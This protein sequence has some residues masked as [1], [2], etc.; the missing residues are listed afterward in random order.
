MEEL[1]EPIR[2]GGI[3]IKNRFALLP[4]GMG[5][6]EDGYVTDRLIDFYVE[7][8]KGGVGLIYVVGTYNDFGFSNP[9]FIALEDDKF[10]PGLG[11]LADALHAYGA[12]VFMQLMHMGA[13]A[14][15]LI[16]GHQPVSASA[17]R[18]ALTGEMPRELTVTEIKETITHFAEAAWRVKEGGLDGVELI[19][20]GGYL[21]NQ[22]LSPIT[23]L[24][25][26][27]YGGDF[28]KRLRFPIEAV[29]AVRVRVGPG[30]PIGYR[31]CGDEFMKGGNT[32][33]EIRQITQRI[34]KAGV[35]LVSVSAGWHQSFL[36]LIPMVVPRGAYSYLARGIKEVVDVP[37]LAA[38]RINNPFLASEII[39]SGQA[40]MVGMARAL[41]ADP[42]LPLK[43]AAGRFKEIRPCIACNQGC[44]DTI[45]HGQEVT[46]LL[47]PAVGREREYAIT[48]A[49]SSKKVMVIGGGPGGLEAARVLALRGHQVILFEKTDRL[50]GQLRLA[51]IPPER[52]EF[53]EAIRYYAD[54]MERL[55]VTLR[56]GE[57]ATPETV[58]AEKPEAVVLAAG[59][60]PLCP[61]L[62]GLDCGNVVYA[63][64]VLEEKVRVGRK[65]VIIGGGATGAETA[66]FLARMGTMSPET[67]VFLASRGGLSAEEAIEATHRGIK[68][69]TIL[70]MMGRIGEDI[71]RSTRWTVLQSLRLYNVAMITKAKVE[72]V[73]DKGVFYDRDGQEQF[74][75]ADTVVIAM[76]SVPVADLKERIE[77]LV[78]QLYAIGDCVKPRKAL[79]AVHEAYAVAREI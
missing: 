56:L 71:G 29:R 43:T 16:I 47:N 37:V 25:T 1:F 12:K 24:R 34:V 30:F 23:N 78:P 45:T 76:G 17:V 20:Q 60:R 18:S 53:A 59:A 79:D 70:E 39:A 49:P 31:T 8:A 73:T 58:A 35:D 2:V 22:F 38:N 36:P 21:I 72:R 5:Y 10:L 75:E 15:S 51:A 40:D 64:D 19:N 44:F 62:P 28:E 61:D 3:E 4:M 9:H 74:I 48:P 52:A 32:Y 26:D 63:A 33:K 65:V 6:C 67:A 57:E 55:G 42:E 27:D 7:M 13:S 66:L 54:E 46:C 50:G 69:V 14:P 77:G 11:R 41:L 68:T